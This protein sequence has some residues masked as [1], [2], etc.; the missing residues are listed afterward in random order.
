MISSPRNPNRPVRAGQSRDVRKDRAK[1]SSRDMETVSPLRWIL[2][3]AVLFVLILI[4]FLVVRVNALGRYRDDVVELRAELDA[5][6]ATEAG[7][8]AELYRANQQIEELEAIVN[9]TEQDPNGTP[10]STPTP[11]PGQSNQTDL[12]FVLPLVHVVEP[13]QN[14]NMIARI[15]FPDAYVGEA[16]AHIQAVNDIRN[17][18]HV[19]VGERLQITPMP[20]PGSEED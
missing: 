5:L 20:M 12:D 13:N 10:G 4:V 7:V 3:G 2:A 17:P 14:L 8:R 11:G 18:N 16:I 15:Y 19:Q 1:I 6:I 9:P